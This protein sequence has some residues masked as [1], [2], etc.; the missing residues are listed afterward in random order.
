MAL[1]EKTLKLTPPSTI[2][3]PNGELRPGVTI[4]C[5]RDRRLAWLFVQTPIPVL[6]G[7]GVFLGFNQ[8]EGLPQLLFAGGIRTS[9]PLHWVPRRRLKDFEKKIGE[10]FKNGLWFHKWRLALVCW[11]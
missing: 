3:A 11:T 5:I 1:R 4:G 10:R 8:Q 7:T 6:R 9:R 2:V